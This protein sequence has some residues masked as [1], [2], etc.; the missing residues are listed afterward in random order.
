MD[1][2]AQILNRL[3]LSSQRSFIPDTRIAPCRPRGDTTPK[4]YL[5]FGKGCS[6]ILRDFFIAAQE[7]EVALVSRYSS[8]YMMKVWFARSVGIS[9]FIE[10]EQW[11]TFLSPVMQPV[12]GPGFILSRN[13]KYRPHICTRHLKGTTWRLGSEGKSKKKKTSNDLLARRKLLE[14]RKIAIH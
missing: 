8:L 9:K 2:S 4:S 7:S 1:L 12:P 11:H 3:D 6:P 13:P 5:V 14:S 10:F